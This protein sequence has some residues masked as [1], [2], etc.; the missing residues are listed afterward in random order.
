MARGTFSLDA[1]LDRAAAWCLAPRPRAPVRRGRAPRAVHALASSTLARLRAGQGLAWAGPGS[2]SRAGRAGRA[3]SV[4]VLTAVGS[5]PGGRVG[6][7]RRRRCGPSCHDAV[8]PVCAA[9]PPPAGPRRRVV[10]AGMAP[11]EPWA[12]APAQE[13]WLGR[14]RLNGKRRWA[15]APPH[16]HPRTAPRAR[17]GAPARARRARGGPGRGGAPPWGGRAPP[18][19]TLASAALGGVPHPP[20]GGG[21][22]GGSRRRCSAARGPHG[23]C[24]DE[25]GVGGGLPA[26][27]A[28]GDA[29]LGGARHPR[30]GA[31]AGMDGNGAGAAEQCGLVGRVA[32]ESHRGGL[33]AAGDGP[34]G[35]PARA[36]SG[37][38]GAL[39]RSP[40]VAFCGPCP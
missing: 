29:L 22:D 23:R 35:S 38:P 26:A 5:M 4:A 21:A 3:K 7:V 14:L 9:L 12:A 37:S 33:R 39:S 8:A 31:A 25:G 16:G 36:F 40:C 18:A 1:M 6:L 17:R 34:V 32:V 20:G 27:V 15:P 10:E 11:K 2:C 24:A 19:P 28:G 30:Q 13:A